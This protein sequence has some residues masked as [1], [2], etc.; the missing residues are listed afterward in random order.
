M[1]TLLNMIPFLVG[2]HAL[3]E[4]DSQW[5]NLIYFTEVN[6]SASWGK[7]QRLSKMWFEGVV[8]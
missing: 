7:T 2:T 4:D 3:I 6:S 8:F 5:A 1:G